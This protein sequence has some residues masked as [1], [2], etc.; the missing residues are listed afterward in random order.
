LGRSSI[1][2]QVT[3]QRTFD[4]NADGVAHYGLL[5]DLLAASARAPSGAEA[6]RILNGSAEAYLRMWER[7]DRDAG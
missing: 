4:L 2:R 5:P 6:L 3:G 7:A 1:D